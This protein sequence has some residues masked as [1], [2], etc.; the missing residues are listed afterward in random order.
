MKITCRRFEL[1][2]GKVINEKTLHEKT[3]N[4]KTEK[5]ILKGWG[6]WGWNLG[7]NAHQAR[8]AKFP[9][10]LVLNSMLKTLVVVEVAWLKRPKAL[11][12]LVPSHQENVKRRKLKI[13]SKYT[14]KRKSK[15]K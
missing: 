14:K 12:K 5:R 3:T 11:D 7:R 9:T 13:L 2:S 15:S 8:T 4:S 1:T 6:V 10:P